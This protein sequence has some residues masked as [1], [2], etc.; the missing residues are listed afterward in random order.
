MPIDFQLIR[1]KIFI[2]DIFI[3][4]IYFIKLWIRKM[5]FAKKLLHMTQNTVSELFTDQSR[6]IFVQL[7]AIFVFNPFRSLSRK[8]HPTRTQLEFIKAN[9]RN[10]DVR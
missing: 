7:S 10:S 1:V 8:F 5:D 9:L 3:G 4:A 6:G 2:D